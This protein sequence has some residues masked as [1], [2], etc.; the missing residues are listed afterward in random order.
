MYSY[1]DAW[2][3]KSSDA[4]KFRTIGDAIPWDRLTRVLCCIKEDFDRN[5]LLAMLDLI[6]P[7]QTLA[8]IHKQNKFDQIQVK[9]NIKLWESQ[10]TSDRIP[11]SKCK[12]DLWSEC[13]Y[14]VEY[15]T[16]VYF[17][18]FLGEP[19]KEFAKIVLGPMM[20]RPSSA[21]TFDPGYFV[22]FDEINQRLVLCIRG[23]SSVG[24]FGTDIDAI[25]TEMIHIGSHYGGCS[26]WNNNSNN[27]NSKKKD[28]KRDI[29]DS[30]RKSSTGKVFSFAVH[31]GIWIA[32]R[33][34]DARIKDAF[35]HKFNELS[36]E[37]E[38]LEVVI[39]GHSLGAGVSSLL[40]VI[41]YYGL[42]DDVSRCSSA[43]IR[44]RM[45]CYSFASPLV[46][47]KRG[48]DFLLKNM[49]D[50]NG[51]HIITS[52]VNQIDVVTRM[53]IP[54]LYDTSN[55]IEWIGSDIK[56]Y[57][58]IDKIEQARCQTDTNF[59]H[60]DMASKDIPDKAAVNSSNKYQS[61]SSFDET[62]DVSQSSSS[63]NNSSS[64]KTLGDSQLDVDADAG[65][66]LSGLGVTNFQ[67]GIKKNNVNGNYNYNDNDNK[68][69]SYTEEER[70]E[71][72]D[73]IGKFMSENP[74]ELDLPEDVVKNQSDYEWLYP[75]GVIVWRMPRLKW[76]DLDVAYKQLRDV[77]N[78]ANMVNR[79]FIIFCRI[80]RDLFGYVDAYGCFKQDFGA[81]RTHFVEF[82][83]YK[84]DDGDSENNPLNKR[85]DNFK[86]MVLNT[87]AALLDHMPGEY[88]AT[89]GIS[90]V[91]VFSR[92]SRYFALLLPR[93]DSSSIVKLFWSSI[94]LVVCGV[95][96]GIGR[97][98]K[99]IT[100]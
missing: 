45:Y 21:D 22:S 64:T 83:L 90:L 61:S 79:F 77:T 24:D 10:Y 23:S 76:D 52:V 53:S 13:H 88:S 11:V 100:G 3:G 92:S 9:P 33:R 25:P 95:E 75:C 66:S 39:T 14:A 81:G 56:H 17:M 37:F 97:V 80:L 60:V 42:T 71:M 28:K 36:R 32:A 38:N 19:K 43:D 85:F 26:N 49:K 82:D 4:N 31:R 57:Q 91:T 34:L 55:K 70:R 59:T 50:K 98:K 18:D 99:F 29:M 63:D 8:S 51:Q 48:R 62:T 72:K 78:C 16:Y 58:M 41:W 44:D 20:P 12:H 68:S 30:N 74:A 2:A 84:M 35:I 73:F 40:G 5:R 86:H 54:G 67:I 46:I 94:A 89:F 93:N 15:A 69:N 6:Y 27:N 47:D 87:G 1:I 7:V 65:A 96:W